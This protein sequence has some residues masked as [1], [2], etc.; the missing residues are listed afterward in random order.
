MKYICLK[1][2]YGKKLNIGGV[3]EPKSYN[4][5]QEMMDFGFEPPDGRPPMYI[6]GN[7]SI[8]YYFFEDDF[9]KID[10]SEN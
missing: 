7:D 10:Y 8:D 9:K 2:R 3:Y 5:S 6:V 4:F 1:D